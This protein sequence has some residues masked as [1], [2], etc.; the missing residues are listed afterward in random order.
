M[1]FFMCS[2]QGVF[3]GSLLW[4]HI[5]YGVKCTTCAF[6]SILTFSNYWASGTDFDFSF[7]PLIV[8]PY[9]SARLKRSQIILELCMIKM[10]M[11]NILSVL[12]NHINSFRLCSVG[13]F[14]W[15]VKEAIGSS[16]EGLIHIHQIMTRVRCTREPTL[17]TWNSLFL[18]LFENGVH[19]WIG[20]KYVTWMEDR[21]PFL[22]SPIQFQVHCAKLFTSP[23]IMLV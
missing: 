20:K 18:T 8:A 16:L 14:R 22:H 17:D 21:N 5:F 7:I 9:Y 2:T 12:N 6:R 23:F 13:F 3:P 11:C 1:S 4:D 15:G 19:I 10:I